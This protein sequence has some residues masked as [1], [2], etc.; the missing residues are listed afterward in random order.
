MREGVAAGRP[1]S[2][3]LAR[4]AG[5]S[6]RGGRGSAC[7]EGTGR[8]G[9]GLLTK[10]GAGGR[11]RTRG[12]GSRRGGACEQTSARG[13]AVWAGRPA[14]WPPSLPRRSSPR[15]SSPSAA[16]RGS[17][18][19]WGRLRGGPPAPGPQ[20]GPGPDP[21][22]PGTIADAARGLPADRRREAGRGGSSRRVGVRVR[23]GAVPGS[24]AAGPG[25]PGL[26]GDAP[27]SWEARSV[28][29][30]CPNTRRCELVKQAP[31][32]GFQVLFNDPPSTSSTI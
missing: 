10:L 8:R 6:G 17:W 16:G 26:R 24:L 25:V 31:G 19:L 23:R 18:A 3:P 30:N 14:P 5:A 2:R 1:P 27:P 11:V 7:G 4:A 28:P 20:G 22:A 15:G 12:P 9:P 13:R 32:N 21:R 29:G